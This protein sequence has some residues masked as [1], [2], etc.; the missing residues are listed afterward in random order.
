MPLSTPQALVVSLNALCDGKADLKWRQREV[1]DP[2]VQR[3]DPPV[4]LVMTLGSRL[5]TFALNIYII[6]T[7]FRVEQADLDT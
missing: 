2:D 6:Y 4:T 1:F 5:Q 7:L 3:N